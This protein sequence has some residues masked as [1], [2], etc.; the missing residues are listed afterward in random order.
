[1][2]QPEGHQGSFAEAH[3]AASTELIGIDAQEEEPDT[4]QKHKGGPPDQTPISG[5]QGAGSSFAAGK[6]RDLVGGLRRGQEGHEAI[7]QE[8]HES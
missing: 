7:F 4:N 2:D 8:I 5:H 3:E 6:G 1:M